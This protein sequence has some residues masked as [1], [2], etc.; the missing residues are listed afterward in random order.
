MVTF[1]F[2]N[3]HG[4]AKKNRDA[5]AARLR[6]SIARLAA[7]RHLDVLIFT[8][9]AIRPADLLASLNA[10]GIG[11]YYQVASISK[12]IL[13]FS[14]LPPNQWKWDDLFA[15]NVEDRMAILELQG[16]TA[17]SILLAAVHFYD[18]TRVPTPGGRAQQVRRIIVEDLRKTEIAIGHQRTVLVGDLN[19]HPYEEGVVGA[20]ALHA[21]MS[22][23]LAERLP[24]LTA[25]AGRLCFYNPMWALFGDR[26]PG[27][28]G[29]Y[30]WDNADE[31]TNHFWNMYDQVLIRPTLVKRF[32]R[33]EVLDSDGGQSL[34]TRE[35]RPR[36]AKF[37]DH[38]P[39]FFELNI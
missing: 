1:L 28:A 6:D 34:V 33:V 17:A 36:S 39:L 20:E 26:T 2:W 24:G 5:R 15:N 16:G 4:R 8:E 12:R 21:V 14:R 18:R 25:R 32:V 35:G 27:P 31:P 23:E 37:S 38:L 19:M 22:E 7:H 3:L 9:C 10:L 11:P 29:T 13:F 30:Y